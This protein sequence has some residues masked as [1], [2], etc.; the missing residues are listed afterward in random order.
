M[1]VLL[2]DD[3]REAAQ[4]Y[5]AVARVLEVCAGLLDGQVAA[6]FDHV[7]VTTIKAANAAAQH[8]RAEG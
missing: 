4:R 2:F 7:D 8:D 3:L 1:N 5:G 6:S